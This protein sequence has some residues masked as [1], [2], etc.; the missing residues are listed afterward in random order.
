MQTGVAAAGVDSG[1]V[2]T[3]DPQVIQRSP[4]LAAIPAA[5]AVAAGGVRWWLQGSGNLYTDLDRALYVPDPHLGWRLVVNG[6]I[7]LGLEVLAVLA[8][9]AAGVL[10]AGWW[11][12]RQERGGTRRR[13]LRAVQWGVAIAMLVVP[14]ATFTTGFGPAGRRDRLPA[15][16]VQP[17]SFGITGALEGMPAGAYRVLAHEGSFAVATLRGGGETFEAR[18]GDLEGTWRG[19]PADLRQPMTAEISVGARTVDTGIG[20]R[21]QS[22]YQDLQADAHPRIRFRLTGVDAARQDEERTVAFVAA[23]T[24]EL[25]GR[26]HPVGVTGTLRALDQAGRERLGVAGAV[27]LVRANFTL[28]LDETAVPNDGTFDTDEVP[29]SVSL[30]LSHSNDSNYKD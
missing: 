22:A 9:G 12:D 19:D 11:I 21:S 24:V 25:I 15:E 29:L 8:A 13:T 5:L 30:V 16:G 4:Y 2:R 23:G 6:P 17:P 18:F 20:L 1:S 26:S 10:L 7:W 27:L 14:A 28:H 3:Y